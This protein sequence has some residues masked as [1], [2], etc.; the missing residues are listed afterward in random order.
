MK[1][2]TKEITK[3][4]ADK[5]Q[6]KDDL[7]EVNLKLEVAEQHLVEAMEEQDLQNFTD[8][9]LGTFYL[10]ADV[11]ARV[12]NEPLF[13][14]FLENKGMSDL[15]KRTVHASRLKVIVKEYLEEMGQEVPGIK[16]HFVTKIGVRAP[17]KQE[18]N[19]HK[20]KSIN[21]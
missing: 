18:T 17:K 8:N 11:Y 15:I 10:R 13:F 9:E 19:T 3:L 12:E 1:E 20:E 16:S 2:I 5:Q 21:T 6:L 7:K 4:R 14:N